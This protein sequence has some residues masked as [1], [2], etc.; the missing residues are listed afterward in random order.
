[1]KNI[2]TRNPARAFRLKQPDFDKLMLIAEQL[3]YTFEGKPSLSKLMQG[4]AKGDLL[5]VPSDSS[6]CNSQI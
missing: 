2:E 4:I 5:I 6:R 3:G 1:M